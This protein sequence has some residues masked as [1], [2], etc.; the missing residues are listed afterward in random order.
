MRLQRRKG[1]KSIKV[2]IGGQQTQVHLAFGKQALRETYRP[3]GKAGTIWSLTGFEKTELLTVCRS[4]VLCGAYW[5]GKTSN[6][7]ARLSE[8]LLESFFFWSGD[9]YFSDFLRRPN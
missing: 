2:N 5:G 7:E 9:E 6:W 1:N 8:K 4:N 3:L